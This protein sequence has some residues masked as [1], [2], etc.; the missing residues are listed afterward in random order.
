MKIFAVVF[1]GPQ[2]EGDAIVV[3]ATEEAAKNS[4]V[5]TLTARGVLIS[6]Y[7][8]DDLTVK[9]INTESPGVFQLYVEG[10]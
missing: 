1:H 5:A 7:T 6:G 9:E 2:T 4:L 8:L 10:E 3:A